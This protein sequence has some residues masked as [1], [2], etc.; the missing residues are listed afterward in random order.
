MLDTKLGIPNG[1]AYP[2]SVSIYGSKLKYG[3]TLVVIFSQSGQ[4]PDLVEFARA[5]KD[6]GATLVTITNTENSPLAEIA[7]IKISLMA[8][9]ENAVKGLTSAPQFEKL[10]NFNELHRGNISR[11]YLRLESQ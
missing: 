1:I 11:T 5:A 10:A 2:S 9:V 4:S 8:G 6:G 3:Q 7:N